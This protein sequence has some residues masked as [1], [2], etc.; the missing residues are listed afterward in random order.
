MQTGPN[1]CKATNTVLGGRGYQLP[2]ATGSRRE[3]QVSQNDNY[4][5][6]TNLEIGIVGLG[7]HTCDHVVVGRMTL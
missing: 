7:T 5:A 1:D 2:A 3:F 6:M 4:K